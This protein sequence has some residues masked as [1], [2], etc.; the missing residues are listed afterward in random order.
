MQVSC[1]EFA[2]DEEGE[3]GQD[4]TT[5]RP[6]NHSDAVN[7]SDGMFVVRARFVLA[8]GTPMTGYLTPPTDP[9]D[10]NLGTLQPIII[11]DAGQVLFWCGMISPS[12]ESLEQS[13]SRLGKSTPE[14]VCPIAFEADVAIVGG[15]IR[16]EVPGFVVLEDYRTGRAR[17][18]R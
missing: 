10:G 15:P 11:T 8:D 2:L 1:W 12:P 18:V 7:P 16:G 6:W 13:Y 17:T 5:V 4:E 3:D 9:E 14:H